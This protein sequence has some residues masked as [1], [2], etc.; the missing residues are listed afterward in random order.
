M[1]VGNCIEKLKLKMQYLDNKL[2]NLQKAFRDEREEN[3]YLRLLINDNINRDIQLFEE[4]NML[5]SEQTQECVYELLNND[6]TTSRVSP[7]IETVLKLAGVNANKLSSI[8]TVNNMNVQRLMLSRSH[9]SNNIA[10]EDEPCC[11]LSDEASKYGQKLEGF[12]LSD[13]HGK[14]WVLGLRHLVTQ[15][16]RDTLQTLQEIWPISIGENSDNLGCK[17]IL[18]NIVSTMSDRAATP[19]KFN[20][21]LEEYRTNVLKEKRNE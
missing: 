10:K 9:V 15:S 16:G 18:L 3:E 13:S 17:Q 19:M 5:Y 11:L 21:L 6:V 20:S 8:S 12:H 7:V 2:K 14:T 4:N 1:E